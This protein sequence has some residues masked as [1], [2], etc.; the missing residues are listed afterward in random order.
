MPPNAS[1]TSVLHKSFTDPIFQ[2]RS[3]AHRSHGH[4]KRRRVS[5]QTSANK[6]VVLPCFGP[7][8]TTVF[9]L[10]FGVLRRAVRPTS[11]PRTTAPMYRLLVALRRPAAGNEFP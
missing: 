5:Y 3:F 7:Q 8:K 4:A 9:V 1:F 11:L 10:P 2:V 6:A